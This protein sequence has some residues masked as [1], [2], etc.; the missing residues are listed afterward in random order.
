ME[1]VWR[2]LKKLKIEL[3]LDLAIPFLGR[4]PDKTI[5]WKDTFSPMFITALFTIGKTWKQPKCPS[6]YEWRRHYKYTLSNGISVSHK[7]EIM[8]FAATWMNLEIIMLSWVSEKDKDKYHMI[9]LYVSK[10]WPKWTR[11]WNRN[12]L[13][14]SQRTDL[15]SIGRRV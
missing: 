7:N 14:D 4:Y 12:R 1:T 8:P 15:L 10:I 6:T 3:P 2:F 5:I 13:T 11:L 9:S